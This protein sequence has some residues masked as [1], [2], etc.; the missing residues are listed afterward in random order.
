M[1][2][3]A[4]GHCGAGIVLKYCL[5]KRQYIIFC[6]HSEFSASDCDRDWGAVQPVRLVAP[7]ASSKNGR[8][9]PTKGIKHSGAGL[10]KAFE[11]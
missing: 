10:A 6:C 7:N 1:P 5:G 2:K 4:I 11:D 8:A 3:L 9:A